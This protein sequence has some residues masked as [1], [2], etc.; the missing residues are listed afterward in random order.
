MFV[1]V[2]RAQGPKGVK[3]EYLRLVEAFRQDG[4]TKHRTILNLGRK[5]LI[6]PHLDQ[7]INRRCQDR[8]CI[9]HAG[10]QFTFGN[11]VQITELKKS[12]HGLT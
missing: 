8:S 9:Q 10:G 12:R 1:R 7:L 5:D 2:I 4:K 3:Y 11:N 6:A